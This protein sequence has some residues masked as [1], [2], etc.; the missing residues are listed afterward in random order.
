[1]IS[2]TNR[3]FWDSYA[4]LPQDAQQQARAAYAQ[5]VNNPFHDSLRFKRVSQTRPLWSVRIGQH[6]WALGLR[7]GD[8]ILWIWIGTHAEYDKLVGHA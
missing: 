3:R 7:D 5:F 4:R 1:M 2:K 8:L 6:Y